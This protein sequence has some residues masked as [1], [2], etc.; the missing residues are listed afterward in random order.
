[1]GRDD[2]TKFGIPWIKDQF[3][4]RAEATA[5]SLEEDRII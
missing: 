5:K 2:E 3:F 4:Y 1:M